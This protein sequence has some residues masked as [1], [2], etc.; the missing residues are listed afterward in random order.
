M[1]VFTRVDSAE[2]AGFLEQYSIGEA[3]AL[4][5][6]EA[7]VTNSN[8]RLDTAAGQGSASIAA[9]ITAASSGSICPPSD[10]Y[11]L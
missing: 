3:Q 9:S 2:L 6:I 4:E 7:G 11:T 1:S 10:A 5:P 8:Y